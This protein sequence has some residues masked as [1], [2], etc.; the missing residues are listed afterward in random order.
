MLV[1][2]SRSLGLELQRGVLRSD[3]LFQRHEQLCQ[4]TKKDKNA[5]RA[6]NSDR[7]WCSPPSEPERPFFLEDGNH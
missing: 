4:Q 2:K 3:I 7:R 6:Q 5:K 1:R